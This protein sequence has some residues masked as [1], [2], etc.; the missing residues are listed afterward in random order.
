M[1]GTLTFQATWT[2]EQLARTCTNYENHSFTR[3]TLLGTKTPAANLANFVPADS[4]A[5][6]NDLAIVAK[7]ATP[8]APATLL[9]SANI[10]VIG[11]LTDVDV[12][13]LT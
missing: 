12:Y 7:G 1:T 10:Y 5:G 3:L 13:R 6:L 4:V 9:F 2:M 11:V 8:S